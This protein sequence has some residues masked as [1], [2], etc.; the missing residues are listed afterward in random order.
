M[1]V[2]AG[3]DAPCAPAAVFPHVEVL[4]AYPAWMEMV[5]RAERHD[6]AGAGEPSWQVELRAR[7]G[8]LARSKRL[9]MVRTVHDPLA[10]RVRFERRE[11]DGRSHAPWV[12]DVTVSEVE[13]GS[14]LEMHLHY[15]GRLWTGGVMERALTEQIEA[16]RGRLLSRLRDGAA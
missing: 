6:D 16:G 4:D 8:P 5:H 11:L 9:R 2:T 14:R 3:L 10:G 12:L 13:G 1:D 7:L 15:G